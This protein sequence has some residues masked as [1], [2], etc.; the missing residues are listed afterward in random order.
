MIDTWSINVGA[1][2]LLSMRHYSQGAHDRRD[3]CSKEDSA[4]LT[5]LDQDGSKAK[6]LLTNR[7]G[8][9]KRHQRQP[10]FRRKETACRLT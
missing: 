2:M 7:S 9:L 4:K 6:V 3:L 1:P 5:E 10:M 8:I